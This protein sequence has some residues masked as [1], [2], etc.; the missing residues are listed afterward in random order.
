[1]HQ[2]SVSIFLTAWFA[3]WLIALITW[4]NESVFLFFNHLFSPIPE[5]W[6]W[7]TFLGEGWLI[8]ILSILVM[9]W[10]GWKQGLFLGLAPSVA[11]LVGQFFKRVVFPESDRPKLHFEKMHRAIQLPQHVEV[12]LHHSFPSGHTIGAFAFFYLLTSFVPSKSATLF[13]LILASLVGFSR[14]FLAQHF[15]LDVVVGS[16]IGILVAEIWK[17]IIPQKW[18]VN[19]E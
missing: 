15:P 8:G 14:I 1:M 18:V 2:K 17:R 11:G 16:F 12:H 10:K 5:F 7:I 19:N 3:L 13:F 9:F 4:G 6:K